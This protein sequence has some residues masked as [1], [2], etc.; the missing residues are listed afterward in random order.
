MF[1][2]GISWFLTSCVLIGIV[3]AFWGC[4]RSEVNGISDDDVKQ[5]FLPDVEKQPVA[6]DL[7]S[8]RLVDIQCTGEGEKVV[9]IGGKVVSHA[10]HVTFQM[11]EVL[12]SKSLF[13]EIL[14]RI[15]RGL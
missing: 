8:G 1:Y 11:A 15:K 5:I 9:K 6:L 14:E 4:E 13:Y 2:K 3:G 12:V 10:R 7:K